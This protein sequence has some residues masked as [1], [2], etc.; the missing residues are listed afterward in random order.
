MKLLLGLVFLVVPTF[1]DSVPSLST[2]SAASALAYLKTAVGD[3]TDLC[4]G[5]AIVYLE[6]IVNGG[7]AEEALAAATDRYKADHDSGMTL[8]SGSACEASDIAWRAAVDAGTD[9]VRASAQ[10]FMAA[11]P[12]TKSGNPC[13]TSGAEYVNAILKGSS[14]LEANLAAAKVFAASIKALA[15]SGKELRDPACAAAT[16]AYIKAVTD[17]PSAPNAAATLA[18]LEK[19]LGSDNFKF[20]PVCWRSTE[21]YFD[22]YTAGSDELTANRAAAESFLE[23][24]ISGSGAGIP[25]DSPCA[26][27]TIAYAK[28]I[29]NAPSPA[30]SAAMEAFITK[31]IA[32]GARQ[33]DPVCAAATKAYWKA[34]KSGATETASNLAAAEAFFTAWADGLT[35]PADSPCAA[36]TLAY[37]AAI[38]N[39]PS[40]A[41]AAAMTSFMEA[42][43]KQSKTRV[44]DAACA[45][46]SLAYFEAFKAGREELD[47][48][49]AAARA[50]IKEY[51]KGK[52]SVPADSPCLAATRTYSALIR[53]KH[54]PA[55]AAAMLKFMDEAVATNMKEADPVCLAAAEAYFEA[56]LSGSSEEEANEAAGVAYLDAVSANPGFQPG[57]PCGQSAKA[58]IASLSAKG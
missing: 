13:A 19:A 1:S 39:K 41:N 14:H 48:N 20:D 57:S 26:A 50:F 42:M 9:P 40:S 44:S 45:A 49:F 35:I 16:K 54:S 58:Y 3:K 51:K 53:N 27:A 36:A 43:L 10:A 15:A 11:W 38:A 23:E 18:F 22:A 25:A 8:E 32:N 46:A 47:A 33:P 29:R 34:Y 37:S 17:K 2:P 4:S 5:S 6:T 7:T 12:G 30:N 28:A 24:F 56:H 52:A 55:N 21:A 31:M